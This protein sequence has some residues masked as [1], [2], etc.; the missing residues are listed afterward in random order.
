MILI[1]YPLGSDDV[2]IKHHW[3]GC[4]VYSWWTEVTFLWTSN[5]NLVPIISF[6]LPPSEMKGCFIL[7]YFQPSLQ[8]IKVKCAGNKWHQAASVQHDVLRTVSQ[9]TRIRWAK[10]K[11]KAKAGIKP[12]STETVESAV[13]VVR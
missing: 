7:A 13:V 6:I 11:R 3:R 4:I 5:P 10:K 1:I 12:S 2:N 9:K 8:S